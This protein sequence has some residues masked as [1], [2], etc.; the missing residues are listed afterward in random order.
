MDDSRCPFC[1]RALSTVALPRWLVWVGCL[2]LAAA[3]CSGEAAKE[4]TTSAAPAKA[5]SD[6]KVAPESPTPEPAP[7]PTPAAGTGGEVEAD[8]Q[9]GEQSKPADLGSAVDPPPEPPVPELKDPFAKPTRPMATKYGLP[10]RPAKKY[11]GPPRPRPSPDLDDP[12]K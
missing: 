11:G 1:S 12:F 9:W 4:S 7:A 6:A 3:A 10:P 2:P 5:E 8:S